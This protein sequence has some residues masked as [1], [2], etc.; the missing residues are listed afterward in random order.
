MLKTIFRSPKYLESKNCKKELNY[1][2]GVN[3]PIVPVMLE[4]NWKATQWLGLI[5][6]GL[7]WIDFRSM[8]NIE[9]RIQS[10]AKEIVYRAGMKFF[11][12]IIRRR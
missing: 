2:D 4:R 5:T 10:L 8:D 7:L 9:T 6:A 12:I 1:A 11:S 3:V